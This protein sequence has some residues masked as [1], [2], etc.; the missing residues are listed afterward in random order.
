MN[1]QQECGEESFFTKSMV[2]MREQFY[3]CGGINEGMNGWMDG[4]MNG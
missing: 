2:R 3:G 1:R 4:W